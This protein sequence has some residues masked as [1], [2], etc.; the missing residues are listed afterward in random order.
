MENNRS[1]LFLV[2]NLLWVVLF[3]KTIPFI[4]ALFLIKEKKKF[5]TYFIGLLFIL[6][7][8][9]I[10]ISGERTAFFYLNLSTLFILLVKKLKLQKFRLLT[11]INCICFFGTLTVT[12]ISLKNRMITKPA[13]RVYGY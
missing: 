2:M 10:Y 5:E 13:T 8:V 7:D 11:F 9:L 6:I 3:V 1:H 4:F 12:M